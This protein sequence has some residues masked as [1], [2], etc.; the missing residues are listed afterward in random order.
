M[1]L[2][3]YKV[4][5]PYGCFSN[6]SRHPVIFQEKEWR[7]VEHYYQAQK[8]HNTQQDEIMEIIRNCDSPEKAAATGRNPQYRLRP[9]WDQVKQGIMTEAVWQ[10]FTRHQDIQKIL[11]DTGEEYLVEN[12]PTD[13]YWGCG[14]NGTGQNQLGRILMEVRT[15]ILQQLQETTRRV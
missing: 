7:T 13:Y 15:K 11:L 10:K 1:T 8:F 14:E 9:D 2:Y 12:S 4:R 5:D 6:F 3:F